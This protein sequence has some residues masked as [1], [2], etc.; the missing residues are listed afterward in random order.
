MDNVSGLSPDAH[1]QVALQLALCKSRRSFPET[2]ETARM[3][4]FDKARTETIHTLTEDSHAL[5]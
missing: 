5:A 3:R 1:I 2:C 4:A